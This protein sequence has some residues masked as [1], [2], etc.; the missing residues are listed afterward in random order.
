[1]MHQRLQHSIVF[2]CRHVIT[3]IGSKSG[4][5]SYS[6]PALAGALKPFVAQVSIATLESEPGFQR[7]LEDPIHVDYFMGSRIPPKSNLCWSTGLNKYIGTAI[8]SGD[9]I[10]NHGLWLFP[11]FYAAWHLKKHPLTTS[12]IVHSPRGMLGR[13]ARRISAWKKEPVWWLWQKD[14]LK[15]AHCLHAT[16]E[17]EYD[18]IRQ[19]GLNN[20]VAI[21]P[22]GIDIPDLPS[23][24]R[25]DRNQKTIL[26]LG[27]IHPK[28]GLDRLVR[29]WAMLEGRF[30][31]WSLRLI[32]SAEV[33]HDLELVA[34]GKQL[35]LRR[36]NVQA[37]AYGDAKW[38]A[39]QSADLFVLPTLNENFGITVAEALACELPVISTKGAP[40]QGLEKEGCGWW[41][42]HGVEPLAATLVEAMELDEAARAN[43]G[44][45][46]K[47]W[48]GRDF[49][50][51]AIGE[52]MAN[53]YRWLQH[54]GPVPASVRLT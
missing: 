14:A 38:Q 23:A 50:W 47:S 48:M 12:K 40:W 5:P 3:S 54:G 11:N 45:R 34:L 1:M 21:I 44:R 27:R 24:N 7:D 6:V 9:I 18:E 4:G 36:F 22:N 26:S 51:P 20:P 29:A 39:Y 25:E 43:M 46:G 52:E 28:K 32:G 53:V 35:N 15:A 2:A 10:H 42:D 13:E 41:I 16:A 37:A 17:S 33:G 31:N 30:P 19:A 49:G 8:K